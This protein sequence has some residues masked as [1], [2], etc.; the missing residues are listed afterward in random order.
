MRRR[1][2]REKAGAQLLEEQ[3][4]LKKSQS[5]VDRGTEAAPEATNFARLASV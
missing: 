4:M 3:K 5:P 2:N 1:E